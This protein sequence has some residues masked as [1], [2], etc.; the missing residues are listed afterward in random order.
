MQVKAQGKEKKV[1]ISITATNR[2]EKQQ[3]DAEIAHKQTAAVVYF[4]WTNL[5]AQEQP[6]PRA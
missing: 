4:V 1:S 5:E 2:E 6:V 3:A